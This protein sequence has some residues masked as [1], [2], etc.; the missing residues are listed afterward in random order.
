MLAIPSTTEGTVSDEAVSSSLL[1][2]PTSTR[3]TSATLL[4]LGPPRPVT[5]YDPSI[6]PAD[7]HV[8]QHTYLEASDLEHEE[9]LCQRMFQRFA[10]LYG[11]SLLH[12][13][14]R[15]VVVL[16]CRAALLLKLNV[17]D[18]DADRRQLARRALRR[19]LNVPEI[20]DVGD[21]FAA[22]FLCCHFLRRRCFS[23]DVIHLL[24]FLALAQHLSNVSEEAS[25]A[26]PLMVFLPLAKRHAIRFAITLSDLIPTFD[27]VISIAIGYIDIHE[28]ELQP[29]YQ[30]LG[31]P[32]RDIEARTWSSSFFSAP[33]RELKKLYLSLIESRNSLTRSSGCN[34]QR[35]LELQNAVNGVDEELLYTFIEREIMISINQN[36]RLF[37]LVGFKAIEILRL[38]LSQILLRA[39]LPCLQ[40]LDP[41]S[42]LRRIMA[43][44]H[45]FASFRR[46]ES[47]TAFDFLT[48]INTGS[49][50]YGIINGKIKSAS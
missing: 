24:G 9:L 26:F 29:A 10:F 46:I 2:N 3:R 38:S 39:L 8:L 49:F 42:P 25:K 50:D 5:L 6:D 15:H 12:P 47:L 13:T 36:C 44:N 11:Q 14:L 16:H 45:L 7:A 20:V 33:F 34:F 4:Q 18:D 48:A 35:L 32:F 21:M 41:E 37:R 43:A 1:S 19:R 27:A 31:L 40:T 28:L 17:N 22:F 23:E 30:A